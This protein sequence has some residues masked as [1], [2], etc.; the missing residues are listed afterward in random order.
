MYIVD[1]ATKKMTKA[2]PCTFKSLGLKERQD[3]Q[4]WIANE[5]SS[6]GED[7]LIIQ[8]EFAGFAD[9]KERLD[10]LA[11][12]KQGNIVVIENK[13]DDSGKDVTWQA[14]KYA[15]YCS[16]LSK[17]NVIDIYQD[18]LGSSANAVDSICEFF[19]GK[20]LDDIEIN[21]GDTNLRIFLVAGHFPIEV[22]STVLWLRNFGI[23]MSCFKV[24]PFT[25]NGH[26]LVDFDQII[27]VKDV[28]DYTVKLANK[29][30]AEDASTKSSVIRYDERKKFWEAFIDYNKQHGGLYA[31]NSATTDA[32]LGKG[33]IG[34]SG[35]GVN[36]VITNDK[37]RTEL[38]FNSGEK[39]KNKRMF[40][41]LC[42]HKDAIDAAI[43]GLVWQRLDDKVTCRICIHQ[44]LSFKNEDDQESIF[45]FF[46]S[47]TE[48]MIQVF[49]KYAKSFKH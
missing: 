36:I 25:Y 9:T 14:L 31:N 2:T 11:L 15:S 24:S 19:D 5:P 6:L 13:L 18:Y 39:D 41:Y 47:T 28:E 26:L 46:M 29:K 38:Y 49:S 33:G 23:D 44:Q 16:S 8:K 3:L 35:V 20:E 4:E 37:C 40:D 48:T 22:S 1:I 12:D 7:L 10:L 45:K 43:P 21:Q 32:W 17:Q 30:K 34:M 27:P 42:T